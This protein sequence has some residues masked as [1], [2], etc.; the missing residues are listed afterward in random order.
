MSSHWR[1]YSVRILSQNAWLFCGRLS[2]LLLLI[3]IIG[4]RMKEESPAFLGIKKS[5]TD[6]ERE[7]ETKQC[8][9]SWRQPLLALLTCVFPKH[10]SL[11]H[12]PGRQY[13]LAGWWISFKC[14]V[15]HIVWQPRLGLFYILQLYLFAEANWK[16]NYCWR[17]S[18]FN[19]YY[20]K[21]KSLIMIVLNNSF[22]IFCFKRNGG[23]FQFK[24]TEHFSWG[25]ILIRKNLDVKT[26][27]SEEKSMIWTVFDV[28]VPLHWK[29]KE[30]DLK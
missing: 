26:V 22:F 14:C 9:H 28:L 20:V 11:T 18:F 23:R 30:S 27:L 29:S 4:E 25:G 15:V 8:K 12:L 24:R 1:N 19:S 5:S 13:F 7:R 6:R 17:I 10:Y 3:C 2:F 21:N 16:T